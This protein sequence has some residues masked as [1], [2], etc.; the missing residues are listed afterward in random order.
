MEAIWTQAEEYSS[1]ALS[2][3]SSR[4]APV[5]LVAPWARAT[6]EMSPMPPSRAGVV[7]VAPVSRRRL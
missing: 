3:T 1:G 6:K 2:T 7:R 4:A 5:P